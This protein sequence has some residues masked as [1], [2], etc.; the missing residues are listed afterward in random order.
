MT[1]GASMNTMSHQEG[2]HGDN[3]SREWV[4]LVDEIINEDREVLDRLA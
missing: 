2:E 3:E 4:G 1:D